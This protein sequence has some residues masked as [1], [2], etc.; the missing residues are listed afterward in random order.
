[1]TNIY[2]YVYQKEGLFRIS[3][4]GTL[5]ALEGSGDR[6]GFNMVGFNCSG[7]SGLMT[8]SLAFNK[9]ILARDQSKTLF[10]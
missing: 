3:I 4:H 7:S 10:R 5:E 2:I 6:F 9:L 8:L 1:M